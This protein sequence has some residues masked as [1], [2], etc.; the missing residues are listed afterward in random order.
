MARIPAYPYHTRNAFPQTKR[1]TSGYPVDL[2]DL[3]PYQV[4]GVR[5]LS[6]RDRALLADEQRLGKTVQTLRALP[7]NAS[8]II[9]CPAVVRSVWRNE[10][11][12]WRPDLTC[13]LEK[14]LSSEPIPP[15]TV[16]VISYDSLPEPTPGWKQGLIPTSMRHVTL[17]LDE[18]QWV[19][20]PR[21][22]RTIRTRMLSNQCG[23]TWIL[24]GTPLQGNP[25]D[26]RGV[27]SS[28]GLFYDVFG[29]RG[30][31]AY[32][33]FLQGFNA[34]VIP[35]NATQR[36]TVYG[37]T[38]E[39]WVKDALKKVMLRRTRAEVASHLP[40]KTYQEIVIPGPEDLREYLDSVNEAWAGVGQEELPPF[41]LISEARAAL[42]KARTEQS[43]EHVRNRL[44][45]EP[46]VVFS[47][48]RAPLVALAARLRASLVLGEASD[49]E[50][51]ESI[52]RFQRGA[53]NCIALSIGAGGV[54]ID[55]SRANLGVFIDLDWTPG[56]NAQAEDRLVSMTKLDPIQI[57]Y[58]VTDHPLDINVMKIL[59]RKIELIKQVL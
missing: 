27:L 32:D 51:E 12:R 5:W 3:R 44:E 46:V 6:S 19:K 23:R 40:P 16:H 11:R 33:A 35:I 37:N 49:R 41:E 38:V 15:K 31:N 53:T 36:K 26:L 17:I 42:A 52:Q 57:D 34:K 59:R 18:G 55:L 48:H 25:D 20:N 39:P 13:L 43:I 54:G 47:A 28:A 4:D 50:R 1:V 21:A 45:H 24:T 9:V 14:E 58:L 8:A 22:R 29:G 2:S 30:M 56:V 7:P 10:C